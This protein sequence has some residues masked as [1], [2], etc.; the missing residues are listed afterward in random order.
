MTRLCVTG[1]GGVQPIETMIG[2]WVED[3]FYFR[4]RQCR[5]RMLD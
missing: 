4:R 1:S 2:L 5:L 3:R